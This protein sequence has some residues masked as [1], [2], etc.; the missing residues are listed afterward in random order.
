MGL[1]HVGVIKALYH[2]HLLPRI[3]SGSSIGSLVASIVCCSTDAE[4]G[5]FLEGRKVNLNALELP[6]ESGNL[7]VKISRFLK[8]GTI[9]YCREI[10]SFGRC[11]F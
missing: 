3:I 1:T 4:L 7:F 8:H 6:E 9:H 2:C 10:F 5:A 11:C